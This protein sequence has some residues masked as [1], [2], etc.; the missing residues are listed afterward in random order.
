M[1]TSTV[2][3]APIS[4]SGHEGLIKAVPK[5]LERLPLSKVS[6]QGDLTAIKLHFGERGNKAYVPPPLVRPA[7]DALKKLGARP[8]LTDANTLYVGSRS[9]SAAHLETAH[10]HGFSQEAM[11]CPVIIA[12]GLRGGAYVEVDVGGKHLKKVKLAHD[13][14]KADAIVCLTHFKGHELAGFGGSIKNLG[15]GGGARGAKLA[16]HSD[17]VPQVKKSKCTACGRCV[18]EC[19]SEAIRIKG[20]AVIDQTK[21]IGCGSCI[22]VCPEHAVRNAWDTGP[23]AM[24]EKMV[25]HLAGFVKLHRGKLA[26]LNYVINVSPACDCYGRTDPY[27]VPDIGICASLDPVALDQASVDLVNKAAGQPDSALSNAFRPGSDKFRDIYPEVDWSVQLRYAEDMGL[28]SRDY[29][30]VEVG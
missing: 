19:P 21:C 10:Q 29:R 2:Y 1:K 24:Q 7:V 15:M 3:F 27:I 20:H 11:G 22:V 28:G 26:Y 9:D 16:M 18:A 13:L 14:A 5:L 30:L 23:Q 25:E 4:G 17:I 8:F 12:D 6:G